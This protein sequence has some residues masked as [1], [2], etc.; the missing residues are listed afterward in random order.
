ML[1][2]TMVRLV[3]RLMPVL[4]QAEEALLR[5]A[6]IMMHWDYYSMI[7]SSVEER[8]GNWHR[9]PLVAAGAGELHLRGLCSKMLARV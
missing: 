3:A 6:Y 9:N 5:A 8:P 4:L 7:A 1:D 2:S